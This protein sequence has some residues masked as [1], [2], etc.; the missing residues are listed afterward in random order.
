MYYTV[1][2]RQYNTTVYV[3]A[4]VLIKNILG[5]GIKLHTVLLYMQIQYSLY[6]TSHSSNINETY[7]QCS[8]LIHNGEVYAL[9]KSRIISAISHLPTRQPEL[10]KTE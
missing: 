1:H 9:I 5:H 2:V 8:V 10:S 6:K 4:Q 3:V 7:F